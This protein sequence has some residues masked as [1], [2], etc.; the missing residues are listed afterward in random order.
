M[1]GYQ[2]HSPR[3]CWL[4]PRAQGSPDALT[5]GWA[6]SSQESP[7]FGSS[8][9]LQGGPRGSRLPQRCSWATACP[10]VCPVAGQ[11]A[12][13]WGRGLATQPSSS[14][15]Q[16]MT[17]MFEVQDLAA[18]SPATVS[19]CGMVYLEPSVLGLM[20]FVECWLRRLPA[21]LKPHE[22]QF[23]ALFVSFLEVS[24]A[25]ACPVQGGSRVLWPPAVRAGRLSPAG[26][27]HFC[28]VL[29]EGGGPLHQQQPGHESPQAARLL[30]QA[31]PA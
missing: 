1:P 4:I 24:E 17:M 30:L 6:K 21:L 19:R 28:P 9:G 16:A 27:H 5:P 14:W 29:S 31:L 26:I 12:P 15:R 13:P 23:R 22:E 2:S 11:A 3:P 8:S 18:A 25:T 20:P 7:A 10:V